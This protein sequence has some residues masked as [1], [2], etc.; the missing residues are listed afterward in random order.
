MQMYG[1]IG[2]ILFA[3]APSHEVQLDDPRLIVSF[4]TEQS[5][6]PKTWQTA[7]IQP[8]A[9]PIN[10]SDE[11]TCVETVKRALSKYPAKLTEANLKT[12]YI[13]QNLSFYGLNYGGTNCVDSLYLTLFPVKNDSISL[14][15]LERALHHEFS[16]I[17]LR[18]YNRLFPTSAWIAANPPDFQYRGDGTQSLREGTAST[19]FDEKLNEQ[20]FLA[21]YSTSSIEEDFNM[22]AESILSG[23]PEF[24]KIYDKNPA[25][26]KK[27]DLTIAFYNRIDPSF[28]KL[29]FA[30]LA[31]A[32]TQ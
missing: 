14:R 7:E 32:H 23:D 29:S 30:H 22:F 12:V 10:P 28:N 9:N 15:F 31:Q 2:V 26:A 8:I 17:L 16:S 21:Q 18:N 27:A 4:K 24:W 1:L 20:G 19:K 11:A 6:F 3:T 5:I 25:V 13:A